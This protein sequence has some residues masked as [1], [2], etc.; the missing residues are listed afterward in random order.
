MG[1]YKVGDS[2]R[3]EVYVDSRRVTT[4]SGFPTKARGKNWHDRQKILC[5]D[6]PN[7]LKLTKLSF[8]EL[9]D[10]FVKDYLM[11]NV[12]ETTLR[13]YLIDIDRMLSCFCSVNLVDITPKHIQDFQ[14][15]LQTT[16]LSVSSI[17]HCMTVLFSIFEKGILWDYCFV[18]P[19]KKVKRLKKVEK[20]YK[21]WKDRADIIKFLVFIRN[22]H[23]FLFFKTA[24]ETGLRLGE[25]A[26]LTWDCI[27]LTT[28]RVGL[29]RQYNDNRNEFTPLKNNRCR[30]VW[31]PKET[32]PLFRG[33]KAQ[34]KSEF[35]FTKSDNISPI[36]ANA[37]SGKLFKSL[38]R[39]AGVPIIN[40][41]ALRHTYASHYMLRNG[42]SIYE[43]S[44][45]LGHNSVEVTQK[46]AHLSEEALMSSRDKVV[47]NVDNITAIH[48]IFTQ[49]V[50][51]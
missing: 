20:P 31:I 16:K 33:L 2:W 36:C 9:V 17:N 30:T 22:N 42:A 34:A 45:L 49:S 11:Q 51:I 6:N 3:A 5:S 44:K 23:Y 35:V 27:D 29:Y 15:K 40:F 48:T 24:L 19:C 43:L 25:I 41:H 13:R 38:Q 12:K 32:L 47:F 46:Y 28:G 21:W 37:V 7:S 39:K 4:K 8:K 18:N 10:K 26:G 1:V 50:A 14:N